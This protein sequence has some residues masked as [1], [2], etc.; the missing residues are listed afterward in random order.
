M[1]T[2]VTADVDGNQLFVSLSD[3]TTR[4]VFLLNGLA[5]VKCR[6]AAIR[7]S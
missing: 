7:R 6:N 5:V 2:D 4:P 1:V 3:W